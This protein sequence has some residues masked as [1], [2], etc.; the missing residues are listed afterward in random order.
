MADEDTLSE[1]RRED[2]E[3]VFTECRGIAAEKGIALQLP[4]L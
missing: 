3:G 1:G 4:N 2:G